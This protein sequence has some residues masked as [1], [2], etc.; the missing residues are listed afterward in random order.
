MY[1][2]Q[3]GADLLRRDNENGTRDVAGFYIG[4]GRITS[5]VDTPFGQHSGTADIDGYSLGAYWTR[6]GESGWYIDGVLQATWY[7]ASTSSD[8]RGRLPGESFGTDGWGFAASLK[9]GRPFA[10]GEGWTIE[11]QAQLVYQHVSLNDD[12]DRYGQFDYGD[13]DAL[14]GRLGARL[15]RDWT[16]DNGR[17]MSA[18]ASADIWSS[19]GAS[20]DTTVS[21]LSGANPVTFQS[22]LGGT[23]GRVGIGVSGELAQNV[24]VFASADYNFGVGH[25]DSDAWGGRIGLKVR[26]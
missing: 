11:P 18:W 15:A 16:M 4:A 6:L 19:F 2:L 1:G 7:D 23:W 25:G 12:A 17:R 26:W 9:T 24:S 22:N 21:S 3:V 14:Y 13:T 5:D 8:G 10:L 20:G